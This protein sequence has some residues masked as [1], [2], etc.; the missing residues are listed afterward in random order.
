MWIGNESKSGPRKIPYEIP[1]KKLE[2]RSGDQQQSGIWEVYSE[3]GGGVAVLTALCHPIIIAKACC[4]CFLERKDMRNIHSWLLYIVSKQ[5]NNHRI[6][7]PYRNIGL[8]VTESETQSQP[9]SPSGMKINI[10]TFSAKSH[11]RISIF[12]EPLLFAQAS[13]TFDDKSLKQ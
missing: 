4:F 9:S 8:E 7:R 12:T 2:G 6:T 10:V 1:S 11:L 5:C 3:G 13:E